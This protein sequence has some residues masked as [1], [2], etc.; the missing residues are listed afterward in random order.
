MKKSDR[1]IVALVVVL[2]AISGFVATR[3]LTGSVGHMRAAGELSPS[4]P[5]S[6]QS[7]G[8]EVTGL[9]TTLASAAD[10]ESEAQET[11][12]PMVPYKVVR[13]TTTT[14][15]TTP[16]PARPRYEVTAVILDEEDPTAILRS[17]GRSLI[18]HLGD[19]IDGG[20]VTAIEADGVTLESATGSVKLDLSR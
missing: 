1:T 11:R 12:D 2:T 19:E 3:S 6:L 15:S 7:R 14:T 9:V 10:G 20:R 5:G 16:A 4:T 13:R 17:G 8:E 18:V